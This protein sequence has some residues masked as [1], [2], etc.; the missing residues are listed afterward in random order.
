MLPA[1]FL[2]CFFI[3]FN[4]QNKIHIAIGRRE[5]A[6]GNKRTELINTNI[7]IE[8]NSLAFCLFYQCRIFNVRK[9]IWDREINYHRRFS[10]VV[11]N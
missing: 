6:K 10:F 9:T 8:I 2:A 5:G 1:V 7:Q 3:F 4:T 11:M